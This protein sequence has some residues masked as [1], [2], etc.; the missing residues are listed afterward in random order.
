MQESQQFKDHQREAKIFR[1][2]VVVM[3]VFM[4]LL[5]SIL[6]YRYYD[7]QIVNY[8]EYATQS[9]RNRVHVQPVPPT[10]GL[11]FDRNGELLADNKA[12][13]TLSV[14]SA[15]ATELNNTIELLKSLIEISASDLGKFYKAQKQRRHKL[16][17]V[18]LRY[19]LTEEEIA[20]L[21]V[22]QHLLDGV[23]VNAELVRNYPH[24]DMFAHVIGYTGRISEKE[25]DA[26]TP[27][28]LQRYSGTHAIGKIGIEASYEDVLLGEVGSQNVET[29]ARGRVMRILD[30]IDSKQGSDL[31]LHLDAR[32]Q[33]T[34][35]AAMRGRRGAV[36]AIDVKTGGVLAAV[37]YP[38]FDPNLFV[39]GIG[40]RDYKSLNEDIDTPLFNRFLQAQYPPGS[41]IKPVI[42]LAGL[43]TGFTDVNRAISDRGVFTL[44][45]SSRLYRDWVLART[46]GGHGR[47][48]LKAAISQSCD[49]YFWD[50][51]NRMGIDNISSFGGHFGLGNLTGIDIPSERKGLWPSREWKRAARRE[52]WYPG[53]TVNISIGQGMVLATPMQLAV[54]TATIANRGVRY[55]PQFIQKIGDQ[56]HQPIVDEIFETK[57][58]YWDAI[59]GGMEEVMHG[60]R[61]TARRVSER[62]EYRMAGKSGTAQVVAIAQNAKYNSA[63]LKERHRDHALFVAF[64]PVEAPQIAVA[65]M[66]ENA[67]GGSSQAAP[68]A[69]AMMDAHL[70]GYYLKADEFV[71]PVGFH[72]AAII[73]RAN[74]Y[75][76]ERKAVRVAKEAEL[77]A[78]AAVQAVDTSSSAAPAAVPETTHE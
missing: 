56:V 38:G 31:R 73:K 71:P 62:S 40:Y 28:Q 49:T 77:A 63:A 50:L 68:V 30:R 22:N 78:K 44:P 19:R 34:A 8:E 53:D 6:V 25:V 11:I 43:H 29:N 35:V 41:T 54:M 2:R 39:T 3:A 16:D 47:V 7:L 67:E 9:D 59:I 26:F 42:G 13:F 70:L 45:G 52:A 33:E 48:D 66:L 37:S 46:G 1:S 64:A 12:S 72:H 23:E 17:P 69:R 65:V 57:P 24:K 36:V 27:E 61:G 75:I 76:S 60:A 15:D 14:V 18:P 4:L 55:R 21:A 51:G 32:M 74:N 58:E 20:R 10:R 5:V